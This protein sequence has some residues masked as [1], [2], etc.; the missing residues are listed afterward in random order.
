MLQWETLSGAGAFLGSLLWNLLDDFMASCSAG[1][2]HTL[3]T[4][5][6]TIPVVHFLVLWQTSICLNI[7]DSQVS[8]MNTA[9]T[10]RSIPPNYLSA[11]SG[12]FIESS[13]EI[14]GTELNKQVKSLM[15]TFCSLTSPFLV[16]FFSH[17]FNLS[18][19]FYSNTQTWG[20]SM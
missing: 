10:W 2:C 19:V 20:N 15:E 7:L 11:Y 3:L 9:C 6:S 18:I 1:I 16:G 13:T 14:E 17:Y 4:E 12:S 5:L 8:V